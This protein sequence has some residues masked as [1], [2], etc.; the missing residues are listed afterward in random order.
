MILPPHKCVECKGCCVFD[1][2]DLWEI[3]GIVETVPGGIRSDNPQEFVCVHLGEDGCKL[4]EN[5][6]IEC[7]VYP[8]RVM[9]FGNSE[10]IAVC[11]FCKAVMDLPLSRVVDFAESK[12][13][14]F[15]KLSKANPHIIKEHNQEYV[16]LGRL[17]R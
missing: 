17:L 16:I 4:G 5:K 7:A 13:D 3:D 8:F 15:S 11:K 12:A 10:I 2:E 6:P 9:R 14:E 1:K